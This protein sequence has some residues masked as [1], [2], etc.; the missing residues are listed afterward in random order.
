MKFLN[1]SEKTPVAPKAHSLW[2]KKYPYNKKNFV[3]LQ[4]KNQR[5]YKFM[6]LIQ[7]TVNPETQ[8][9]SIKVQDA[10]VQLQSLIDILR[11]KNLDSESRLKINAEIEEI[12]NSALVENPLIR[13]IKN[14][15]SSI[16]RLVEKES[17][18]VPI[19]YYRN[20]WIPLGLSMGISIGVAIGLSVGNLGLMAV[21]LPIGIGIGSALGVSMDKKAEK[22]GRQL[23][24]E[25][26]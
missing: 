25:I 5:N 12:N 6:E 18:L 22:E 24:I 11:E 8:N 3:Y 7:L 19:N 9:T 15:Q 2:L 16:I 17:K 26:K 21:G 23:P 4:N 14:K 13:F 10:I 20:L 1:L